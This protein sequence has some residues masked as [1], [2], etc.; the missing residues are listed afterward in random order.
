MRV[1]LPRP[2]IDPGDFEA[3]VPGAGVGPLALGAG[4]D[5]VSV[6]L[7]VLPA[8]AVGAA[9]V[10]VEAAAVHVAAGGGRARGPGG[11]GGGAPVVPHLVRL[12]HA[13]TTH[14]HS[15]SSS[16]LTMSLCVL[17]ARARSWL[18]I[19]INISSAFRSVVW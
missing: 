5:A 1:V 14:R 6:G 4:A 3:V 19:L 15:P 12:L 8:A 9:V 2:S 13:L 18:R 17:H 11:R 7:A 10:E 16:P